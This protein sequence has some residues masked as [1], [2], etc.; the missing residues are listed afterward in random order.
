[1]GLFV[2]SILGFHFLSCPL[3]FLRHANTRNNGGRIDVHVRRSSCRQHKSSAGNAWIPLAR[4][5][6]A[7]PRDMAQE[8]TPCDRILAPRSYSNRT[9]LQVAHSV[10]PLEFG[11]MVRQFPRILLY[12]NRCR[13]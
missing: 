13:I 7:T 6:L 11:Y 4:L 9:R 1:M 8:D 2:A 3:T 5:S 12:A 10:Y